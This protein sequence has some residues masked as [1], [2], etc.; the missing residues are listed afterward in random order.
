MNFSRL[1]KSVD[2]DAY[3]ELV[4]EID[5]IKAQYNPSRFRYWQLLHRGPK[6]KVLDMAY[7]PHYRFLTSWQQIGGGLK[8]VEQTSYYKLQKLYG[9]NGQWISKK[10]A[11]FIDLYN[12]IRDDG[13]NENIVILSKPLV[14]NKYNSTFEIFEGH[15]RVA[16]CL[17]LGM[18]EITCKVIGG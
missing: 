16:C 4:I 10:I 18:K 7:S 13:Y 3:I 11:G 9:R 5:K 2:T 15:H 17:V 14:E 12:S 6:G 1:T 8:N